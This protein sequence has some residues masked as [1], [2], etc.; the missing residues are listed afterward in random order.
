MRRMIRK[1]TIIGCFIVMCCVVLYCDFSI[2]ESEMTATG[3]MKQAKMQ[4]VI[5]SKIELEDCYLCGENPKS[6]MSYYR[7]LNSVGVLFLNKWSITDVQAIALNDDGNES[8]CNGGTSTIYNS[9]GKENGSIMV[10]SQKERGVSHLEVSLGEKN[11]LDLNV[12]IEKLCQLCLNRVTNCFPDSSVEKM[13]QKSDAFVVDFLSG[14]LYYLETGITYVTGDY[15]IETK[16]KKDN[17]ALLVVYAPER[18]IREVTK[19]DLM[20]LK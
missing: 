1:Y 17:I 9:F 14:Q 12:A 4:A 2:Q 5:Q 3:T 13:E 8:F 11:K 18:K 16:K 15:Y 20:N 6:L 10:N 7:K 19:K